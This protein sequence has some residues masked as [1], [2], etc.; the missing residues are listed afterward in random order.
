MHAILTGGSEPADVRFPRD[1]AVDRDG[2]AIIVE[3]DGVIKI[4]SC[5]GKLLSSFSADRPESVG[6]LSDGRILVS[7]FP[8]DNR[9][10]VFDRQGKL[11]G[12]IGSPVK[13][14][15]G[16]SNAVQNMGMIVVDLEDN[17]YFG[18]RYTL[19]PMIRRFKSDG[20]LTAEWHLNAEDCRSKPWPQLEQ[21]MR[22]TK[23]RGI[24]VVSRS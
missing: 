12:G 3:G 11:L 8:K 9:M 16:F 2:N 10:S 20:T 7:G 1:F 19:S 13:L 22:R 4:F 17:I 23:S 15:E 18:S 14:D 24:M 5:D 6:T 21:N